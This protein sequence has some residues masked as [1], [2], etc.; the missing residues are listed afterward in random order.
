MT[1]DEIEQ[2]AERIADTHLQDC[3]Y[4]IVY[5]DEELEEASE[6]DWKAIHRHIQTRLVTVR[7]DLY[8][9]AIS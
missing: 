2:H 8:P 7:D 4:S 5:E 1:Q 6:D 3:E 9:F